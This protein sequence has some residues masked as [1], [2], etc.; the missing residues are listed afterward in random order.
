MRDVIWVVINYAR[1]TKCIEPLLEE[2]ARVGMDMMSSRRFNQAHGHL[3]PGDRVV[4]HFGGRARSHP[5]A[6]HLVAA[7]FVKA[8]ARPLTHDDIRTFPRLWD[9][10]AKAFPSFP[11][12]AGDIKGQGVI[13]YELFSCES[14]DVCPLRRPYRPPRGGENFI[15]LHRDDSAYEEVAEWWYSVAPLGQSST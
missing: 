9:L 10:T 11:R 15:P 2:R 12:R 13:S 3:L 4:M 6:Q 8:V 7:G 5:K 1:D 14:R